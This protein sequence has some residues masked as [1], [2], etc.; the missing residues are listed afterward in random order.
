MASTLNGDTEARGFIDMTLHALKNV[1]LQVVS[2]E[3]SGAINGITAPIQGQF[4]FNTT[5]NKFGYYN[6]SAWVY[7][8]IGDMLKS[9]YDTNNNGNV[10]TADNALLLGGQNLAYVLNLANATGTL[11]IGK[12]PAHA[13]NHKSGGS[14]AIKL[15]ELAAPTADV[16]VSGYKVTNLGTATNDTDAVNYGQLKQLIQAWKWKT[17]S[18]KCVYLSNITL[19]GAVTATDGITPVAGDRVLVTGQTTSTQNGVYVVNTSGVWPRA[20][21]C[22]AYDELVNAVITVEQGTAYADS[23]WLCTVERG[24]TLGTTPIVWKWLPNMNDLSVSGTSGLTKTGNALK[25]N[26]NNGIVISSNSVGLDPEFSLRSRIFDI[27]AT[28]STSMTVSI[29][30]ISAVDEVNGQAFPP[31]IQVYQH[32][33]GTAPDAIYQVTYPIIKYIGASNS[34]NAGYDIV[35]NYVN[36]GD[37]FMIMVSKPH[38]T[39]YNPVTPTQP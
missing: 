30:G 26:V 33:S 6:G 15:N 3:P 11:P 5:N 10:D 16:S 9:T 4:I 21:D 31:L 19:S 17:D 32:V 12:L 34:N 18:V 23:M 38:L 1:G 37:E 14:D 7:P 8:G 2:T 20:T 39:V 13:V 29:R 35:F 28:S 25:V 22:D 24:G 36:M 27:T